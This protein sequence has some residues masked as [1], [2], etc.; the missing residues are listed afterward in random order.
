M[1]D[2]N[3]QIRDAYLDGQIKLKYT[4]LI[5]DDQLLMLAAEPDLNKARSTSSLYAG[6]STTKDGS[7]KF[8]GSYFNSDELEL[9]LKYDEELIK[10]ASSQILAGKIKLNPYKY[11]NGKNALTYSDFR[12]IFFFDAMLKENKYH[13]VGSL[14]REELLEKIKKRLK[15]GN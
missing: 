9:L 1:Y 11:G 10:D 8:G 12:D 4:G 5:N 2:S 6:V 3:L 7:L 14:K 15:E 13:Q